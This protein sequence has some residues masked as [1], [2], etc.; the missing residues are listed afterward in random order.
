MDLE[1]QIEIFSRRLAE[2]PHS[3]FFA[4]LA[5]LLRQ[6][7]RW[8]DALELV[9]DGLGRHPDYVSAL[10][11]KGRTLMDAG[12]A[13]EARRVLGLV[14]TRDGENIVV[15]RLLTE[16]ARSRRAWSEAIPLLEKLVVLDPDD[17]RWPGAL[18]EAKQFEAR[19]TYSTP[20]DSSFVTMTL[21]DIYL[22][23]GYRAKALDALGQMA[24]REPGRR[25]IQERIAQVQG[26]GP[27]FGDSLEVPGSG[28]GSPAGPPADPG[29]TRVNRRAGEKKQFEDWLERLRQEGGPST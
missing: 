1:R 2:D 18:D 8:E 24:A 27:P 12:R 15:L 4:P 16:D 7:G 11:V 9:D 21:V 23:Q 10:V 6:A 26:E 25:D 22:A 13:E 29:E 14:L 17:S 5:D 3:R 19:D 20:E 28:P